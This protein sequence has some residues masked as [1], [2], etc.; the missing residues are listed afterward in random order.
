M[1]DWLRGWAQT[2]PGT[3][4]WLTGGIAFVALYYRISRLRAQFRA[5]SAP[6]SAQEQAKLRGFVS[7]LRHADPLH[8]TG[9]MAAT[10]ALWPGFLVVPVVIQMLACG[11]Y[12]D[13]QGSRTDLLTESVLCFLGSLILMGFLGL[14]WPLIR[15]G[16]SAVLAGI[17]GGI[18]LG[19]GAGAASDN[20][21]SHWTM[22]HTGLAAVFAV[23][24]GGGTGYA[25]WRS[26]MRADGQAAREPQA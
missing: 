17:V 1:M 21:L 7:W 11:R 13:Y 24:F 26:V 16:V 8:R 6:P 12:D 4:A 25:L 10:G 18:P 15:N 14:V 5:A 19:L 9:R 22:S 23:A 20:G 2:H 3:I